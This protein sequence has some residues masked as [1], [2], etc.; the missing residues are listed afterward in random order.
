MKEEM[1]E[2]DIQTLAIFTHHH[3]T[4]TMPAVEE[5]EKKSTTR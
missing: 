4:T 3:N 1:K 2:N 5:G